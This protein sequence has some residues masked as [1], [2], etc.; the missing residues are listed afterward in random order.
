MAAGA[1]A[2]EELPLYN[3]H[4]PWKRSLIPRR[5]IG[6]VKPPP[7]VLFPKLEEYPPHVQAVLKRRGNQ[8]VRMFMDGIFDMTHYGHF[9]ALQQAKQALPN[10]YLIAGVSSDAD[11]HRFKGLAL[12][13]A[14]ERAEGLLHCRWVDEVVLDSPWVLTEEFLAQYDVDMVAHD[15]LPYV[16]H[17]GASA[18]GDVYGHLR[19]TGRF[20]ETARTEGVSTTD[21]ILRIVTRYDAFVARNLARGVT[22]EEMGVPHALEA[23]EAMLAARKA[24]SEAGSAEGGAGAAAAATCT[25]GAHA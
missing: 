4:G 13:S 21:L 20:Y 6:D 25:G 12:M 5:A 11:T 15:A 14:A 23:V 18:S 2:S 19:A 9:R 17:S 1:P 16:D 3:E 22:P 8:P 10:V 7:P 24:P